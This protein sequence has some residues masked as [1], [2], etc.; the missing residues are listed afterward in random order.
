LYEYR[1]SDRVWT[2]NQSSEPTNSSFA[3]VLQWI[4]PSDVH[5]EDTSAPYAINALFDIDSPIIRSA[6]PHFAALGKEV[7]VTSVRLKT[8]WIRLAVGDGTTE[9]IF[10]VVLG[11]AVVALL[12][13]MYLNILTVGNV[14]SAGRAVR[15]V[16]RQ[17]LLVLK[18][19]ELTTNNQ[20]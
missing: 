5:T 7:R 12:L 1:K 4:S 2:S 11:Y 14:K 3:K 13:A 17:Q 9:K 10:A 8:V 6:E 18:V 20:Y 16:V 19:W 15:S